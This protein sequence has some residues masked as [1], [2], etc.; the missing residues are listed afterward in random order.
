MNFPGLKTFSCF[1]AHICASAPDRAPLAV[2]KVGLDFSHDLSTL[3]ATYPT[4]GC[5]ARGA[6]RS[7]VDLQTLF[8]AVHPQFPHTVSLVNACLYAHGRPLSKS[9]QLR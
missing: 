3:H 1:L 5:F 4:L 8:R 6:M 2:L 9:K 7:L